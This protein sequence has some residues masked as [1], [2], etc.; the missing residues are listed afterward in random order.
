MKNGCGQ[1]RAV[2]YQVTVIVNSIRGKEDYIISNME[3]SMWYGHTI[4]NIH[5]GDT[6]L[7]TGLLRTEFFAFLAL[8]DTWLCNRVDAS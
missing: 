6:G 7:E 1:K 5:A 8:K 2:F 4:D 3:G